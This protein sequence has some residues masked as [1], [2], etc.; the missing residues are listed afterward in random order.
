MGTEAGKAERVGNSSTE[1]VGVNSIILSI[2]MP[3]TVLSIVL[4]LLRR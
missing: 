4:P 2:G 3:R 1:G